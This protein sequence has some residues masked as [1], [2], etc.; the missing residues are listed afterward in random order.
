ME[1]HQAVGILVIDILRHAEG[2]TEL[3][4]GDC[5]ST[6]ED[7]GVV[8][9]VLETSVGIGLTATYNGLLGILH[10]AVELAVE[11]WCHLTI[12]RLNV[13]LD[14][15]S[16]ESLRLYWV[17]G[18]NTIYL[19]YLYIICWYGKR[20]SRV[21]KEGVVML[22][23]SEVGTRFHQLILCT[24]LHLTKRQ[25][26]A[27]AVIGKQIFHHVF[28][29]L[30]IICLIYRTGCTIRGN[31]TTILVQQQFLTESA[32]GI[33]VRHCLTGCHNPQRIVLALEFL[34]IIK[35]QYLLMA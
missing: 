22:V 28:V 23:D 8:V 16:A 18:S 12:K 19:I 35:H 29:Y 7:V 13:S 17:T 31:S 5:R 20:H 25:W 9:V 1:H 14:G 26:L 27:V 15:N 24:T 3:S 30:R 21:A 34:H 10:S 32:M 4:A 11:V 6:H 33:V 2:E